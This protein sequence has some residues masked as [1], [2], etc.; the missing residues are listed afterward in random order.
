MEKQQ[1][2]L[3][4]PIRTWIQIQSTLPPTK[5]EGDSS[6]SPNSFLTSYII[7]E[8]H[9]PPCNACSFEGEGSPPA[10]PDHT[11]VKEGRNSC[12]L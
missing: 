7:L 9:G 5:G 3:Q 4:L 10:N 12:F 8:P 6:S 2:S 11:S 1:K